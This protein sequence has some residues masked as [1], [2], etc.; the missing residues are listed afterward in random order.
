M[1][2]TAEEIDAKA[3][4]IFAIASASS[5]PLSVMRLQNST[6]RA[7]GEWTPV[8]VEHVSGKV[9]GLLIRHGWKKPPG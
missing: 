4:E 3:E 2:K 7:S 9:M 1:A 8:E 5:T 6:L